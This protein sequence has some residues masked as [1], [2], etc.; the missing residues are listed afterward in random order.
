M[1]ECDEL[2][3]FLESAADNLGGGCVAVGNDYHLLVPRKSDCNSTLDCSCI[4]D[5]SSRSVEE[6]FELGRRMVA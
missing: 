2:S 5:W 1:E 3:L 4:T 6:R